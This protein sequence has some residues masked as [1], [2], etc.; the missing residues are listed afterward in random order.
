MPHQV[1]LDTTWGLLYLYL[2]PRYRLFITPY[3][4]REE[5]N[6]SWGYLIKCK[7][8]RETERESYFPTSLHHKEALPQ[9]F[10]LLAP[11]A[12]SHGE[13]PPLCF[14]LFAPSASSHEEVFFLLYWW[15]KKP[16]GEVVI[17]DSSNQTAKERI[18]VW[19]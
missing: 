7:H 16:K 12:S 19:K 5:T 9:Y 6:I 2:S 11:L 8:Q 10:L 14:L 4:T 15:N 18:L 13:D 3:E 17:W 1:E